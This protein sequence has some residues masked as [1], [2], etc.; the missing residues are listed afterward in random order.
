MNTLATGEENR[1]KQ[2]LLPLVPSP[3]S[4]LLTPAAS[5]WC[6]QARTMVSSSSSG[7]HHRRPGK[8]PPERRG[9]ARTTWGCLAPRSAPRWCRCRRSLSPRAVSPPRHS[10][11]AAVEWEHRLA[12]R[13]AA[14]VAR[15]EASAKREAAV[16]AREEATADSSRRLEEAE[17]KVREL[18]LERRMTEEMS[19]DI[20]NRVR[21]AA[22]AAGLG[23]IRGGQEQNLETARGQRICFGG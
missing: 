21:A 11:A 2:L 22:K 23:D 18:L 10:D 15:E 3:P 7:R 5:H 8:R 1:R 19:R 13:E 17:S 6:S 20:F 4:P 12:K 9:R 14:V 16:V